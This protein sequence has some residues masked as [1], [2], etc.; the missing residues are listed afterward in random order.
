MKGLLDASVLVP[1]FYGNHSHHRASLDLF[2]Q[3]DKST[4]CCGAHSL[5]EVY[6]TLT[7]M[8]RS[9]RDAVP[10]IL[11]LPK[12]IVTDGAEKPDKV[13]HRRDRHAYRRGETVKARGQAE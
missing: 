5:A 10:L 9:G 7:R 1:V 8:P 12:T 3:F 2:I 4:G 11:F 13:L 6:S